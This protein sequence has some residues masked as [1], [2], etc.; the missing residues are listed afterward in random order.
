M[1]QLKFNVSAHVSSD[2]PS[3]VKPVLEQIIAEKGTI[4][5]GDQGRS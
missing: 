4:R 3:A 5:Q 2:N 1:P